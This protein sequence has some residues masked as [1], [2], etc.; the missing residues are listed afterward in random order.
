MIHGNDTRTLVEKWKDLLDA[1]G[2]APIKDLHKRRVVASLFENT[3]R[4][5]GLAHSL[6][7]RQQL[8]EYT[9]GVP[10]NF[11]GAS[12][13]TAGSGG[14]DTFDPILIS[15]IR[16][17]A[18]NLMAYDILGVQPMTGPTGLIFCLRPTYSTQ[19]GQQTFYNEVNTAHATVSGGTNTAGD[20]HVGSL[21]GNS[22]V[23]ANLAATGLYNWAGG[24]STAQGEALGSDGNTAWPEMSFTIDKHTVTA[25]EKNLKGEY[26]IQI[27]QDLKAVHGLDADQ[28]LSTIISTELLAEINRE[29]VRTVNF[30]ARQ[31]SQENTTVAG[32][33]DLDTDSNGRW[34]VEKFK[35][36]MFHID[37]EC[38]R[39]A[40]ETRRGKGNLLIC[41]SDVASALQAAGALDYAPAIQNALSGEVDDTGNTFVGLLNGRIKVYIDPYADAI[42]NGTPGLNYITVGYKGSTAY[43]AGLFYCPYVPLQRVT[44]VD[45]GTFHPKIGY[46]TRYGMTANPFAQGLSASNQGQILKDSNVYYRRTIVKNIM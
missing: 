23:S 11:M 31:G 38:N 17:T 3:E 43:D 33:F 27:A 15:M 16:R 20:K 42:L 35:G 37:R 45:P 8:N 12:S 9:S 24:M 39:I 41:S 10:A 13:S 5:L 29:V 28:E 6:G 25:M 1:D 4:E 40:K 7:S 19:A 2:E 22:S 44:A 46:L 32:F 26:T 36:L 34:S 21:P 14:I 18:P 30:T